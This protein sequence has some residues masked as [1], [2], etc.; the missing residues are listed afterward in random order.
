MNE[1]ALR[2]EVMEQPGKDGYSPDVVLKIT[3]DGAG[4]GFLPESI[5]LPAG[6][7]EQIK[8]IMN[9]RS[10]CTDVESVLALS[11]A[12]FD[13]SSYVAKVDAFKQ[14]LYKQKRIGEKDLDGIS[15]PGPIVSEISQKVAKLWEDHCRYDCS[16]S[17][18]E[19]INSLIRD[20]VEIL[21][22]FASEPDPEEGM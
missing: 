15:L 18:W 8:G 17:Y 22:G 19:N 20:A 2:I 10:I 7:L 13:D 5:T 14:A 3:G 9:K 11:D 4:T 6:I 21:Y 1:G 12:D 16:I